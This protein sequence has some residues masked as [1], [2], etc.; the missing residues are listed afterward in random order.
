MSKRKTVFFFDYD[1]T[2]L[3]SSF[4]AKSGFRVNGDKV[5]PENIRSNIKDL[6]NACIHLVQLAQRYGDIYCVTNAELSWVEL[7]CKVV[8]IYK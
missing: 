3:C 6:E 1:D 7:S 2:I 4:L 5:I 8:F